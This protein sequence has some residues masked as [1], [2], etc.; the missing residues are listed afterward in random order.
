MTSL[1]EIIRHLIT[2][3][4]RATRELPRGLWLVYYPLAQGQ[5]EQRG[6]LIAG[7]HLSTPSPTELSTVRAALLEALDSH[8][9]RVLVELDE[10]WQE[11]SRNDWNGYALEW[12]TLPVAVMLGLS[13]D[14]AHRAR[15]GLEARQ[16]RE[17]ARQQKRQKREKKRRRAAAKPK[18]ML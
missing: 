1:V 7:R 18:P 5:L 2:A 10:E 9:T 15:L 6:R 11:H 14:L 4:D 8:P 12:T 17:T 13:P 3:T 16:R